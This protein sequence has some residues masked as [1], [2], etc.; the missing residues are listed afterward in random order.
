MSVK[1]ASAIASE[2]R[3]IAPS[4]KPIA[5][6]EPLRAP[7]SKSS[8]PANRKAS[9]KAPRSRGSAAATASTGEQPVLDLVGDEMRDDFAVGLGRELGA[10][11]FQLAAQLA[12]VL[13]DAVVHDG[14]P[15]G[16]VRMRVVLGRPAV[17]RPAGVADADRAVE[18]LARELCFQILELAFGAPARQHAVLERRH[19]GGIV[20]AVLEAL[21][22]FDQ[23]RR[24]RLAADVR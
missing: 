9:A 13:D 18:R 4:P 17:R 22:R 7:I 1:G 19:A 10:L 12:E 6:G 3:Y 11:G 8:S 21:E 24:D 16:R 20:A 23:Q 5:S 2:P 15:V 14:E